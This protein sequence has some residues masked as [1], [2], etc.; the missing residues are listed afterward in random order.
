MKKICHLIILISLFAIVGCE[1][2]TEFRF[3]PKLVINGELRAGHTIDSVFVSWS[4]D[5]RDRYDTFA[6]LVH[7][8]EI[9]LNGVALREYPNRW[10]VYFYPDRSYRVESGRQY[11]LVVRAGGE[12]A[13][14]TT[15]V[16]APFSFLPIGVNDGDTVQYIPGDSWFSDAFFLLDW[17]KS[18]ERPI[19]RITCKALTPTPQNFIEDDRDEAIMFKGEKED[20]V[21][22]SI[23]WYGGT[24][25]R[26]NWMYFNWRGWH[27]IV[28][29]AT[30]SNYYK[31]RQGLLMGV[32]NGQNFNNVVKNGY[33]LFYSS[34]ADTLHIY[35]KY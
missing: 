3:E 5:I 19:V 31:Y 14:A 23:W 1:N 25:A 26:I 2:G 7:N 35:L 16:P 8:A 13:E 10:G 29:A 30:D 20:R 18:G 32:Q 17:S 34:A 4:S 11:K 9:T 27:T 24:Y 28:A 12:T 22:P 21:N 33:G 15:T 6:Q